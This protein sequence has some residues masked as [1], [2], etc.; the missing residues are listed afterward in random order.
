MGPADIAC[1]PRAYGSRRDAGPPPDLD[2]VR[3]AGAGARSPNACT[4]RL[5]G[6]LVQRQRAGAGGV[7]PAGAV[8]DA[9]AGLVEAD[10]VALDELS[11]YGPGVR[12][13]RVGGLPGPAQQGRGG[14]LGVQA[15][16]QQFGAPLAGQVLT[17]EQVDGQA[18]Q[19]RS[20]LGR[21]R[22]GV[23][24]GR[25]GDLPARAAAVLDAVLSPAGG[26]REGRRP[27]AAQWRPPRQTPGRPHTHDRRPGSGPRPRPVP[28]PASARPRHRRG[29]C[30]GPGPRA[31]GATPAS[32]ARHWTAAWRSSS[33]SSPGAA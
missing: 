21:G 8:G 3:P 5:R 16:G 11:A 33:N 30:P 28:R 32:R 31:C 18:L 26:S 9:C 12:G 10:H 25:G 17:G 13:D 24:R 19:P 20:L 15:V 23:G 14:D 1:R 29:V 27:A 4:P 2:G 6:D 22:G 7:D